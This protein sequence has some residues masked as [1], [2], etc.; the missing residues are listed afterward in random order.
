MKTPEFEAELIVHLIQIQKQAIANAS[1]AMDD[2]QV[3]A[4][5]YGTPKDC[6][7]GFRNQ[8]LR[9]KD[10]FAKQLSRAMVNL[11]LLQRPELKKTHSEVVFGALIQTDSDL[12]L[13]AIGMG[14]IHFK[15][16]DV[17]VVSVQVPIFEA[18]KGK[19]IGDSF[20]FNQRNFKILQII[21]K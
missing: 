17:I 12:F 4:H 15:N 7:D 11:V 6:Y 10:M 18:M 19:K 20:S 8:Q 9:K 2:A 16:E 5:N 3:E 13:I 21:Q 14:I 1:K